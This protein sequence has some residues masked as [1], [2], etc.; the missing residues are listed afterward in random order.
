MGDA[1]NELRGRHRRHIPKVQQKTPHKRV[2]N[3][4]VVRGRKKRVRLSS[5]RSTGSSIHFLLLLAVVGVGLFKTFCSELQGIDCI[6]FKSV[7]DSRKAHH[8]PGSLNFGS[9]RH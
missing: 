1:E 4:C 6:L 2:K 5:C 9:Q 3:S 7:Y 8:D